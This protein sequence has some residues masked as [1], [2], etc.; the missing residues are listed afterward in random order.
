MS[1][2]YANSCGNADTLDS[3]HSTSFGIWRGVI[4]TEPTASDVTST[5]TADFLSRLHTTGGLFNSAFSAMRGSWWYV[6][7]TQLDTGVGTLEMAGTA[8]L[9]ISGNTSN[10]VNY[11][12][13]L[14]LTAY[15][16]LYSYASEESGV[17]TWSRYSKEG[18]GH[19]ITKL[20]RSDA[21]DDYYLRHYWTGSYWYLQGYYGSSYHAGVQVAYA[22]S[23]G[24]ADTV[25]SVH[26]EWAGSQAAS[27][28]TWLAG[29]TADGTKIKAVKQADL[30]VN[31]ATSAGSADSATTAG[32]AGKLSLVSCYNGT[33][34]NDLWS[35]IKS[36]NNSYL[37]TATVY[38]VYNDGG[39]TTYGHVLDIVTVHS[40]HWQSQ[41]WFD[42]GKGG[43]LRYRN[44]DY[45]N[46]SWGSWGEV[47]WTSDIPSV[48]NGTVTITQ[49][50]VNKGSFTMNQSG[51]TTIALT[52]TDTDTNTNYY[53]IRVYTSGFPISS[54]S[55]STDCALYVPYASTS[56]AGVVD[57][58]DQSFNGNKSFTKINSIEPG[59]LLF[60]A[61]RVYKKDG[62]TSASSIY[63]MS[64]FSISVSKLRAG[65]Y[66]VKI[67][68]NTGKSCYIHP[69]LAPVFANKGEGSCYEHGFA[70]F[71]SG[72][73][74]SFPTSVSSGSTLTFTII[75][76]YMHTQ[77]SW[78][79]GDFT[80]SN[81]GG[82][83]TCELFATWSY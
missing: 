42:A 45:N 19:R 21:S 51:N 57:T 30:S 73:S 3:L 60:Y 79:S 14:F 50:G 76:G 9:N 23:A 28:T 36:S 6:G 56:Q 77:G 5:S 2:N 27:S 43:R 48:G 61:G 7:N 4:T 80:K 25:D 59:Y 68:N 26:L 69:V 11:K 39:P 58:L 38:E 31:Y 66:Q 24:N 47:A 46:N 81:D 18:H 35:T 71:S 20:H 75:C 83:F 16:D 52:D 40:N 37:G 70:Y 8:V 53:P 49:N 82:G 63:G 54:Y 78:S 1:V 22:N 65:A 64:G 29:W 33:S 72:D 34:N 15:G 62:S 10:D 13:L 12:S 44:K 17:A 55:G 67:T 41:L 32:I 74:Y